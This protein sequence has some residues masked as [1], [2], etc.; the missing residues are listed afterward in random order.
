MNNW[1][2]FKGMDNFLRQKK[3]FS[4]VRF[5]PLNHKWYFPEPLFL[6]LSHDT[7]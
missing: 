1:P 2:I 3:S 7:M 5:T 6:S 4:I